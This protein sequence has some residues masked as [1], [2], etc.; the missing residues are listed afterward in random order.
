MV[1]MKIYYKDFVTGKRRWTAGKPV[2]ITQG[3]IM[4]AKHL[5]VARKSDEL[6]I[7]EYLLEDKSLIT[8]WERK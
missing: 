2:G 8:Q 7:P 3:G 4:N 1:A 5:I 6:F